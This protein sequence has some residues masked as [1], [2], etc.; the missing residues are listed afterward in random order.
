MRRLALPLVLGAAVAGV[1]AI[2]TLANIAGSS[3]LAAMQS[4]PAY[5]M[6]FVDWRLRGSLV[7]LLLSPWRDGHPA[8]GTWAHP[9]PCA[10]VSVAV[11]GVA[12]AL[13]LVAAPR[14]RLR[15][16]ALAL[17]I[18]GGLAAALVYQLP[19]VAQL[20][21]RLPVLRAMTWVRAGFLVAF[22][23]AMLG[24]LGADAWLR[25]RAAR[26]FTACALAVAV[27]AA[28][29]GVTGSPAARS[30]SLRAAAI[31]ALAAVAAP[32]LTIAGGWPMAAVV[33]ADE[34]VQGWSLLAASVESGTAGATPLAAAVHD[35]SAREGGRFL[36][37]SG[38]LPANL[39]ARE[40][41]ADLRS[42]DPIRPL[43]LESLHRALGASGRDLP[44]EVTAPWAGLAGA[45]GVR[46]LETPS[47]GITGAVESGWQELARYPEGRF[48][49][50]TRALP[51]LRLAT[52]AV[53][54]RGDPGRG[55][56]ES[57]DFATTAVVDE[58]L[59]LGGGG[60]LTVT[61]DRSSRHEAA[62]EATGPVLG[63]LHAPCAPGWS[64]FLDGRRVPIVRANLGAMGIVVPA[65]R[66]VIAWVYAPVGLG[67]G[68]VLTL[69]GLAGCV[70]LALTSAPRRP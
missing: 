50:N 59:A 67:I 5:P 51:V 16:V 2:P 15:R 60:R 47:G 25:R 13:L 28:V 36:A 48:Y 62:V 49:R 24:A 31:P 37:L 65:G 1:G 56:W 30:R 41:L 63:L 21:S 58:A 55:D 57:V 52:H 46:W 22:A 18:V 40:G 35:A 6:S 64:A 23:L 17:V 66:H 54:P 38:G 42:H 70:V 7:A 69:A 19:G 8:D 10:P 68:L 26:R 29:L 45:W 61:V 20:G 33:L 9:F 32:A 12:I 53:S 3:K 34:C 39:G 27:A 4:T 43:S 44:G 11:G 14:R